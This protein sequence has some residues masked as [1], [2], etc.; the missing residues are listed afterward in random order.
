M[1][2]A[3][4]FGETVGASLV[5]ALFTAIFV[6]LGAGGCCGGFSQRRRAAKPLDE[7]HASPA[8]RRRSA[9]YLATY[10]RDDH[11][12]GESVGGLA[13]PAGEVVVQVLLIVADPGDVAVGA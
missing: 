10:M 3:L 8:L 2:V 4:T 13:E 11:C 7:Q 9:R 12:S 5:E 1:D 6:S